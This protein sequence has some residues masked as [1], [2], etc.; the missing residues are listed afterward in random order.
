MWVMNGFK[1]GKRAKS[2]R[3]AQTR[4]AGVS[5]PISVATGKTEKVTGVMTS[6]GKSDLAFKMLLAIRAKLMDAYNEIKSMPI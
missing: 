2:V 5:I 3:S 4:L 6:M 1:S